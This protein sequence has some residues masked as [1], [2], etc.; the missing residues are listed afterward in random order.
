MLERVGVRVNRAG[1][2]KIARMNAQKR[3]LT[4]VGG[5]GEMEALRSS[6]EREVEEGCTGDYGDC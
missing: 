1:G 4:L 2:T 3:G 5:S 6:D